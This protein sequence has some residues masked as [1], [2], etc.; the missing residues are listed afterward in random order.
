[1]KTTTGPVTVER[2]KLRGTEE[3]FASR[4]CGCGRG[5]RR[6]SGGVRP[7][8]DRGAVPV[9]VGDLGEGVVQEGDVAAVVFDP[10]RYPVA[11]MPVARW[12]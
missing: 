6:C 3:H 1:M 4:L 8:Q 12:T 5:D 7:G 10:A 9:G 2:P 11:V